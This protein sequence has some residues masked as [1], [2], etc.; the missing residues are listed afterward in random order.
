MG[1]DDSFKLP[2]VLDLFCCEGGAARV[3]QS[4]SDHPEAVAL[5]QAAALAS[6]HARKA[7]NEF[8]AP[9]VAQAMVGA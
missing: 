9:R 6:N 3:R 5:R 8:Y 4:I 1:S 2:R 7:Q